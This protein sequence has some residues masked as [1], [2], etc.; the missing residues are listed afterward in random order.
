MHLNSFPT[1]RALPGKK[2]E[3][4]QV[5]SRINTGKMIAPSSPPDSKS[6]GIAIRSYDQ[7]YSAPLAYD[8]RKPRS[9]THHDSSG[10]SACLNKEI[11]NPTVKFE[12]S[13]VKPRSSRP[14]TRPNKPT[15]NIT[16]R[17][18]FNNTG[19]PPLPGKKKNLN[20]FVR[21]SFQARQLPPS[22]YKPFVPQVS[23]KGESVINKKKSAIELS[24]AEE[25]E[26]KG[27]ELA[28]K[29]ILKNQKQ[30]TPFRLEKMSLF[31][32]EDEV[33]RKEAALVRKLEEIIL[34]EVAEK[35]TAL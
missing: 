9:G 11:R 3:F 32:T 24:P 12:P 22:T 25:Q 1:P 28:E 4:P 7:Q 14:E 20:D 34:R 29:V 31:Q 5:G 21:K 17:I 10:V 23:R 26:L 15:W 6:S 2:K 35:K 30:K 19:I 33:T 16:T 8:R 27:F 13:S 18:N